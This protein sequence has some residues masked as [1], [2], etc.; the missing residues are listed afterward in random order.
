MKWPYH[1]VICGDMTNTGI[2][3]N[4]KLKNGTSTRTCGCRIIGSF[5]E[6]E[7][8]T[9]GTVEYCNGVVS[10]GDYSEGIL[11]SGTYYD[12]FNNISYIGNFN[13]PVCTGFILLP[14]GIKIKGEFN[15]Y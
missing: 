12:I 9:S 14:N 3:K 6:N 13:G 2:F 7:Q 10:C 5:N 11:V 15:L 1:T 4:G 8:V